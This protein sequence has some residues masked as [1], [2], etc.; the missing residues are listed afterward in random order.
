M[1]SLNTTDD[2]NVKPTRWRAF[3]LGIPPRDLQPDFQLPP[4]SKNE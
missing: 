3:R 4:K 1:G 2:V